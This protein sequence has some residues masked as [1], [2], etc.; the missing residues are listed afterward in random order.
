MPAKGLASRQVDENARI[1]AFI[2][3]CIATAGPMEVIRA[4][5]AFQNIVAIVTVEEV[6]AV[7][8]PKNVVPGVAPQV[9]I[10]LA[11]GD[12]LNALDPVPHDVLGI[13]PV[14]VAVGPTR[15]VIPQSDP[16]AV[17]PALRHGRR[18]GSPWPEIRIQRSRD[19]RRVSLV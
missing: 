1:R 13:R 10:K 18:V 3:G 11:A 7:P 14:G 12:V 15:R 4:G 17:N 8:P 5:S 16:D 6:V 19:G 2:G 9:V